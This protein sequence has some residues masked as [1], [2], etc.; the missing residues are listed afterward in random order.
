MY[1]NL[2]NPTQSNPTQPTAKT[3]YSVRVRVVVFSTRPHWI[4]E[5]MKPNPTHIKLKNLKKYYYYSQ[6]VTLPT[7]FLILFLSAVSPPSAF[8]SLSLFLISHYH[9]HICPFFISSY[10]VILLLFLHSLSSFLGAD[11]GFLFIFL[12]SMNGFDEGK[13]VWVWENMWRE[14]QWKK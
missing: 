12:F 6:N 13:S 2:K 4:E 5:P 1:K 10:C 9:Y 7:F 14:F 3:E 8:S 11:L